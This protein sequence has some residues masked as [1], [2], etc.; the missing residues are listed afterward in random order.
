MLIVSEAIAL[1][2]QVRKESRAS[3]SRIDYPNMDPEQ[4]KYNSTIRRGPDGQMVVESLPVPTMPD[5]LKAVLA[6]QKEL[7]PQREEN[8]KTRL[9]QTAKE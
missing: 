3:H 5:D 7:Q 6:E 9:A 4:G 1:S 8:K 2:A